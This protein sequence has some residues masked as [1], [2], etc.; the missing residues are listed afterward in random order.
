MLDWNSIENHSTQI[1]LALIVN[2]FKVKHGCTGI[3]VVGK[4]IAI[5]VAKV[6]GYSGHGVKGDGL[7]LS[8]A[9]RADVVKAGYVII[10]FVG[11]ED[12]VE[13]GDTTGEHL[14]A[15]VG[16]GIDDDV[17][18]VPRKNGAVA[19]SLVTGV[20]AATSGAITTDNRN[21]L[22]GS[23]SEDGE[24]DVSQGCGLFPRPR[25]ST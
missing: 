20:A 10:V 14:L 17:L 4:G 5:A 21:S 9:K 8:K 11:K 16:T 1:Y 6:L 23:R 7:S 25:P 19:Q 13:P 12:A 2:F 22:R 3:R 18:S 24:P 15:K